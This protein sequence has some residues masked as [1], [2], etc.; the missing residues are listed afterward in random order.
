M[1]YTFYKKIT[2]YSNHILRKNINY[3]KVSLSSL[4]IIRSHKSYFNIADRKMNKDNIIKKVIKKYFLKIKNST[5][6]INTAEFL[7]IS[8]FANKNELNNEDRYFHHVINQLKKEKKN[9]NIIYRNLN[10]HKINQ[11]KKNNYYILNNNSKIIKDFYNFFKII[12]EII[13]IIFSKINNPIYQN[14]I[15]KNLIQLKNISSSINNISHVDDLIEQIKIAKPKKIFLT[16]EGYPWERLLCKK[17]KDYDNKIIIFGYF[18]SIMSKYTN[19]P[20]LKL[21]NKFDPDVILTSSNFIS[22]IFI[23]KKFKKENIINIGSINSKVLQKNTN[24][25]NLK[26]IKCLILPEAFDDEVKFLINFA[27]KAQNK[28]FKIKYILRLHPSIK[29]KTY[30]NNIKKYI[31]KY[32]ISLSRSSMENDIKNCDILFYRGSSSVIEA[33]CK[34]LIPLYIE[35]QNE[36]SLDVLYKIEKYKPKIKSIRDF[37]KFY[38]NYKNNYYKYNLKKTEKIIDYCK[39]YYSLIDKKTINKIINN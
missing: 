16:Y 1:K 26:Y 3:Y 8:N 38:N 29:D 35:K 22:K 12:I 33:S 11:T 2:F 19:T 6:N 30:L 23:Q 27:I 15:N 5:K 18:F 7:I 28:E 9:F 36:L 20:L 13:K 34:G 10:N 39:S 32:N 25:N 4:H 21:N 31:K 14:I 17:I 37:Y 24:S